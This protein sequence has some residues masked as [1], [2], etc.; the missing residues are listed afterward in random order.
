M[1]VNHKEAPQWPDWAWIRLPENRN[2]DGVTFWYESMLIQLVWWL[3]SDPDMYG[4][5]PDRIWIN[6]ISDIRTHPLGI[7]TDSDSLIAF[8]ERFPSIMAERVL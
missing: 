4:H 8:I 5:Y 3:P 7:E 1:A 2:A 6:H